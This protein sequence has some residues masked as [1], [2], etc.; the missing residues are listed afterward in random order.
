[1][2]TSKK[3]KPEVQKW[4][5]HFAAYGREFD[6]W[7][8]RTE[9]LIKRY[10]DHDSDTRKKGSKFNIL[11]SNVQTLTPAVF[12]RLP[13]PEVSRRFHD[14]DPVGRVASLILERSLDYEVSHYPDYRTTMKQCVQDRFLGGR[15]TSWIRY[16]PHMK[17]QKLQLSED[18]TQVSEDEDEP[19]EILDYECAPVDYV[20]W[21][22]FGHVVARTWEEV[23]AVWRRVYLTKEAAEER[24]GKDVAKRLPFDTSPEDLKQTY[25]QSDSERSRTCIHEIWNKPEKKV[26]W[27]S[28]GLK[29]IIE[30]LDDPLGLEEFFPCP[31]PLY[32]TLTNESLVPIPDFTLYQDQANTLDTLSERIEGLVNALQVKGVYDGSINELGRLFT[33]GSSGDLIPVKNWAAFAEKNG[34][35]GAIELVDLD[36]IAR[37]LKECY[38]A[39]EQVKNQVYEVTGISDIVRGETD[40]EETATAQKI[41]GQYASLRLKNMQAEVAQFAADLIRL[42][43]Q[44]ICNHF[45]PQTILAISAADQLSQEDKQLVIPAM[46][47][48]LGPRADNPGETSPNPMR[49]FR[50]EISSDSMIQIDEAEEK[51]SRKNFLEATGNFIKTFEPVIAQYPPLAPLLMEMLKFTAQGFK[52]GRVIEGKFEQVSQQVA[53]IAANPK[54]DPEM[55]KAQAEVQAKQKEMEMSQQ[56]HQ[57]DLQAESQK[58]QQELQFEREKHQQEMA[59]KGQEMQMSMQMKQKEHEDGMMMERQKLAADKPESA[60]VGPDGQ[61]APSPIMQMAQTMTQIAQ[62]MMQMMAQMNATL[63]ASNG[64]KRLTR[65][66]RTGEKMVV[67]ASMQ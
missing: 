31:N 39:S 63:K 9:K 56:T 43:A 10:R 38:L 51:E 1:M 2:A 58:H 26:I 61:A 42:K 37:A 5:E 44:V 49:A 8:R 59:L 52:A 45:D 60:P 23:P 41:K 34:L 54:P 65:D 29:E 35:K 6:K 14:P 53:Q 28:K 3:T 57:M 17:A 32:A 47:L 36:P 22:D 7:S 62:M 21:K 24:F 30:E 48:L 33:E 40:A 55:Q 18:G 67:P 20:H 16:E 19:D 27:L 4:L 15:G 13:K 66:P 46:Q 12:A 50:I 25:G 64:P 11:W